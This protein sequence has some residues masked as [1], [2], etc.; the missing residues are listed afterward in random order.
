MSIENFFLAGGIV[1]WP[2]LGFSIISVALIVERLY[3]WLKINRR[4]R[5]VIRD[6]LRTYQS[7]PQTAIARL[8]QNSEL[9]LC[10]IFLEALELDRPTPDE[11]RLAL[12][13]ASQAELPNLK[14]FNTVFETIIS[15]SPLLGL[16]GTIL[17]LITAFSSLQI[18]DV[19][20]SRT[21]AV[22]GG[23]SEALISTVMGLVVA[24]FTLL[25]ANTFRGL[26]LRQLALIQEYGG[27]L[28]LL[29]RRHYEQDKPGEEAY[30]TAQ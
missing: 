23:I 20:G 15:V 19:G 13:S 5:R 28:E 18:G 8:R 16:L 11:F 3:F 29:Y 25:F 30:A 1:A 21:S 17:G 10:R 9:P 24:I 27:Q 4:Q 12:E 26:Y 7:E 2:L 6:I 22:T 14:R